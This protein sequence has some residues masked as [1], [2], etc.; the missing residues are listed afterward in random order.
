[1]MMLALEPGVGSYGI[2]LHALYMPL[3]ILESSHTIF[4]LSSQLRRFHYMLLYVRLIAL[5]LKSLAWS[6]RAHTTGC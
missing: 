3:F 5:D 2:A 1:M 6:A 4:S